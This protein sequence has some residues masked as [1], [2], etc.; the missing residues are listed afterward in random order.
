MKVR[1]PFS[2]LF[3]RSRSEDY[4]ARYVVREYRRGRSL[5]AALDDP[6]VRN[7]STP[8]QRAGLFERPEVVEAIGEEAAE[9]FARMTLD[10]SP[11]ASSFS[12]SR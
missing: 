4:L 3:P 12:T 8:A 5:S 10:A 9:A 1:N 2:G 6:Y 11:R 7:R